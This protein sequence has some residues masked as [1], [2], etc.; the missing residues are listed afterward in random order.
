MWII[1][2]TDPTTIHSIWFTNTEIV[3][4]C[5]LHPYYFPDKFKVSHEE[6][7]TKVKVTYANSSILSS[8]FIHKKT[9]LKFYK[10]NSI[11]IK[12]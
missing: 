11:M 9:N 6:K 4:V 1:K 10:F 7:Q 12:K 2:S 8:E 5:K 3:K